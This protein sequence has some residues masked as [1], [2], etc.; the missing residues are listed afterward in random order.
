MVRSHTKVA[1]IQLTG[2]ENI[3]RSYIELRALE[4]AFAKAKSVTGSFFMPGS[5]ASK[6]DMRNKVE[7][8]QR[9]ELRTTYTKAVRNELTDAF[10]KCP[11]QGMTPYLDLLLKYQD[12]AFKSRRSLDNMIADEMAYARHEEKLW[13][14][15]GKLAVYVKVRCDMAMVV[16]GTITVGVPAVLVGIGYSAAQETISAA[17]DSKGADVLS[18]HGTGFSIVSPVLERVMEM[19]KGAVKILNFP[20]AILGIVESLVSAKSDWDKFS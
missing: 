4:E 17:R 5:D 19:D 12:K 9:S 18:F 20:Q 6:Q 16:L 14:I 13:G 11:T 7:K 1:T 3:I 2:H 8:H 10:A 15:L